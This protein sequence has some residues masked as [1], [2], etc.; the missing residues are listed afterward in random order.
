MV[1]ST[2]QAIWSRLV[3]FLPTG[4]CIFLPVGGAVETPGLGSGTNQGVVR[5]SISDTV[6]GQKRVTGK[7]MI[8]RLHSVGLSFLL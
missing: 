2:F 5:V 1:R 8:V 3:P 4:F 6:R 7:E